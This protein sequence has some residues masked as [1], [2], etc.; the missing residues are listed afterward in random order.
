MLWDVGAGC[1]SVSIEWMGGARGARAVAIELK[2]DRIS[3]IE[4]NAVALGTEK[5]TIVNGKAP[6]V[7]VDLPQPDAVFIGGG[8]T[9]TGVFEA[10]WKAL[11]P[12]GRLVANTVTLESEA[13][14]IELHQTHGGQLQR[15][16]VQNEEPVGPYRGW[17][18]AMSVTQWVVEKPQGEADD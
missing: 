14:L 9:T 17:R 4:Q 6:E 8:L 18:P 3:M 2:A 10:A 16:A 1:G 7:L 5:I 15:I 12:G 11:C 13:R